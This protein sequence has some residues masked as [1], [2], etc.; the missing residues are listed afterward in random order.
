VNLSQQ[1][2]K[3]LREVYFGDNWTGVNFTETLTDIS[4]KQATIQV[5][6]LN[7]IASLVF[8]VDYYVGNVL[9][10]LQGKILNASDKL[11]F[12]L[13]P[14]KSE[15]DWKRLIA[16]F[17][18]NAELFADKIEKLEPSRLFEDF[19]GG[20]YGDYYRNLQGIV[21]HAHYH[22]GQI[23]LIKKILTKTKAG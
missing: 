22:L 10:V 8:H 16:K 5:Y 19:P 9:K 4:W 14:L 12:D 3:N 7:T 15:D 23:V 13:I 1:I 21:E 17:F 6:D 2:A 11:S 18:Q 20:D